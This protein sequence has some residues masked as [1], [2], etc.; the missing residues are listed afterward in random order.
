MFCPVIC[1]D[2]S[3]RRNGRIPAIS[4]GFN[5]FLP[6][7]QIFLEYFFT[8]PSSWPLKTPPGDMQL[9]LI[10]Y[11]PRYEAKYLAIFMIPPFI[12]EYSTGMV[13]SVPSYISNLG[14]LNPY[15]EPIK[16]IFPFFAYIIILATS[17]VIRKYP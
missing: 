6:P 8:N 3:E 5:I 7:K 4:S 12:I 11:G 1:D 13:I 10:L 15:I 14:A 16:I 9:T 17:L 2:A